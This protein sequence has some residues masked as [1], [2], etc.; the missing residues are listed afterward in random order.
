MGILEKYKTQRDKLERV[1]EKYKSLADECSRKVLA[2]QEEIDKAIDN[3]DYNGVAKLTKELSELKNQ[4]DAVEAIRQRKALATVSREDMSK[5]WERECAEQQK[6]IDK[7]TEQLEKTIASVAPLAIELSTLVNE[8]W[9]LRG[10]LLA[11]IGEEDGDTLVAGKK[12][13]F[14][15]KYIMAPGPLL[16][17][18]TGN[19][20]FRKAILKYDP[21]GYDKIVQAKTDRTVIY[22]K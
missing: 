5:D 16:D 7:K 19:E 10:Q 8:S 17:N 21:D 13:N 12:S 15:F 3:E 9:Q 18:I 11:L 22:Q 6:A 2:K 1:N 14:D 20:L 4:Y